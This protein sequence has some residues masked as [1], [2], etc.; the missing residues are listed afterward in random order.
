MSQRPRWSLATLL[1]ISVVFLVNCQSKPEPAANLQAIR[2]ASDGLTDAVAE[3]LLNA[4][5]DENSDSG[6]ALHSMSRGAALSALDADTA[7]A[8]LL[9]YPPDGNQR[10]YTSI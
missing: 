3:G 4:Y 8:V 5:E 7:D 10:F 1:L 6:F 9:L 2:I